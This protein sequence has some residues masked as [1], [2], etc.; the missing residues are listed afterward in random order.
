MHL[1]L[2]QVHTFMHCCLYR[3][4]YTRAHA[5][6]HKYAVLFV[7]RLQLPMEGVKEG[8][9]YIYLLAIPTSG[10]QEYGLFASLP[11]VVS[12]LIHKVMMPHLFG[13][14][15]VV[16]FCAQALSLDKRKPLLGSLPCIKHTP[17]I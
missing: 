11:L 5:H 7:H 12:E 14:D 9:V 6:A 10:A 3:C 16:L 1:Q 13:S 17:Q 4:T 15:G 8:V 2:A